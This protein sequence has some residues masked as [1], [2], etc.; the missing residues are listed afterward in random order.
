MYGIV[1]GV[2][3]CRSTIQLTILAKN[4]R[5]TYLPAMK[6]ARHFQLIFP[7]LAIVVSITACSS[8]K[9]DTSTPE[10]L[11]YTMTGVDSTSV[12]TILQRNHA[13]GYKESAMGMFVTA[14][15]GIRNADSGYWTY[16][17]NGTAPKVAA[18]KYMTATGDTICWIYQPME[19]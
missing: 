12:F 10:P 4:S 16:T 19:R 18:D 14:I 3:H 15:E 17:V 5:I 11:S 13:I 7:I 6:N 8:E 1:V 9:T 2:S